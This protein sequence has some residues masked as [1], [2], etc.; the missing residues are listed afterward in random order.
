MNAFLT[1][2]FLSSISSDFLVRMEELFPHFLR[3][4]VTA[5]VY[6]VFAYFLTQVWRTIVNRGSKTVLETEAGDIL[7][8]KS[9]VKT[10]SVILKR[11]GYVVIFFT[12]FLMVL[13]EM[14]VAIGPL[15]TGLGIVGVAVGFGA[16]YLVKDLISGFFIV[17]ED[18]YRVGELISID[19]FEG[20]VEGITLRTTKIRAF[21]GQLFIIPNGEIRAITNFSRDYIRAVVDVD[22]PF[23][24][25]VEKALSALNT[26]AENLATDE[27]FSK[28]LLEKIE[29]QGVILFGQ[30]ALR[31]RVTA[32]AK[33]R[34]GRLATENRM[35]NEILAVLK[36]RGIEIPFQ[37][38][39]VHVENK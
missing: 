2:V 22:L 15:L 32:K 17:S 13:S 33:P 23:K 26:A 4:V 34:K 30:S 11:T 27:E 21:G 24:L 18:Q 1:D 29:V 20:T 16:Q 37:Q 3:R 12:A 38:L 25:D 14:G 6:I 9:R 36:E 5:A 8:L 28:E 10:I 19:S 31:Y 7:D 39:E 35:R